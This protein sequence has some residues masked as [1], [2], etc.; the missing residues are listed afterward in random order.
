M[1]H[2]ATGRGGRNWDQR[3]SGPGINTLSSPDTI[4]KRRTFHSAIAC[5]I[6]SLRE[7]TKFHQMCR[8]PSIAAPSRT[9]TCAFV[10]ALIVT[11]SPGRKTNSCC[12]Q[13][14]S[15]EKTT[16]PRQCRSRVPHGQ[17]RVDVPCMRW[18]LFP[19]MGD[20]TGREKNIATNTGRSQIRGVPDAGLECFYP[21]LSYRRATTLVAGILLRQLRSDG[22]SDQHSWRNAP[23]SAGLIVRDNF[24]ARPTLFCTPAK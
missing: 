20:C 11:R 1:G 8:G 18:R 23:R 4:E 15:A 6:R 22:M 5:S 2:P 3:S 17:H 9:M 13:N 21:K 7:E 19:I 24:F 16:R 12:G 14:R 10:M